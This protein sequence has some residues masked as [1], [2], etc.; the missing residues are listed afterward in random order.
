MSN[1]SYCHDASKL[2]RENS[3]SYSKTLNSSVLLTKCKEMNL[4]LLI[5]IKSETH[6]VNKSC[7][8]SFDQSFQKFVSEISTNSEIF[9]SAF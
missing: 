3:K 5:I 1:F 7:L 2:N 6:L 4:Q 8:I 9:L